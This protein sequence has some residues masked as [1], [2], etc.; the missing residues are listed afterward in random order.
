MP[1][2]IKRRKMS[3]AKLDSFYDEL[4][5][6]KKRIADYLKAQQTDVEGYD[7]ETG[8]PTGTRLPAAIENILERDLKDGKRPVI[9]K[10]VKKVT[11]KKAPRSKIETD[12]EGFNPETGAPVGDKPALRK[13]PLIRDPVREGYK[14]PFKISTDTEDYDVGHK[15]GGKVGK[16][17]KKVKA[18]KKTTKARKRA[19]LRGHRK[20]LRGG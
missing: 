10:V 20:E 13:S 3:D 19:A 1:K 11:E 15:H 4:R 12:I 16:G 5:R 8:H 18:R 14:G 6:L 9:S 2:P 17:K 7:P